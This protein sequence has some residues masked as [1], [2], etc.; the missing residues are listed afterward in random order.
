MRPILSSEFL[1]VWLIKEKCVNLVRLIPGYAFCLQ[2]AFPPPPYCCCSSPWTWSTGATPTFRQEPRAPGPQT[3]LGPAHRPMQPQQAHEP[4]QMW[5]RASW[6]MHG[7]NGGP[8]S[9]L[10]QPR[11]ALQ[12]QQA[13]TRDRA[14]RRK[15]PGPA[16]NPSCRACRGPT[17]NGCRHLHRGSSG[18]VAWW[19]KH[20][21]TVAS[22]GGGVRRGPWTCALSERKLDSGIYLEESMRGLEGW[23]EVVRCLVPEVWRAGLWAGP[24]P[25][26]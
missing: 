25:G 18:G 17:K 26:Q 14:H 15:T 22:W 10:Q 13:E 5:G 9:R 7:S 19:R 2:L 8:R 21:A 12:Q 24:G 20:T 3:H 16:G 11:H 1:P 23:G 4:G 6:G